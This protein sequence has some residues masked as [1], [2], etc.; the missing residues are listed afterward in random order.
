MGISLLQ[1]NGPFS[2]H[3]GS[4]CN[5]PVA[6][7][8]AELKQRT[9][10]LTVSSPCFQEDKQYFCIFS[11]KSNQVYSLSPHMCSDSSTQV[12]RWPRTILGPLRK[13]VRTKL[14]FV[15]NTTLQ[16]KF[17]FLNNLLNESLILKRQFHCKPLNKFKCFLDLTQCLLHP[18]NFNIQKNQQRNRK[19]TGQWKNKSQID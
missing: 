3:L 5:H 9:R 6:A 8:E 16:E 14:L 12:T 2:G 13:C 1:A 17:L 18:I 4:L 7:G 10:K 15:V 19:I 11:R